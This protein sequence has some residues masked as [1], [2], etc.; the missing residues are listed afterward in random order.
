[1]KARFKTLSSVAP[2]ADE[3]GPEVLQALVTRDVAKY[4]T[5]LE[6]K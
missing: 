4:K 6:A 5:L 3:H 1:M 2:E